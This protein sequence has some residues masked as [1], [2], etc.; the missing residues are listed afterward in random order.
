MARRPHARPARGLVWATDKQRVPAAGRDGATY[1][2]RV[3]MFLEPSL[4]RARTAP[5]ITE[6]LSAPIPPTRPMDARELASLER[7]LDVHPLAVGAPPRTQIALAADLEA[8]RTKPPLHASLGEVPP[9]HALEARLVS[10]DRP[11]HEVHCGGHSHQGPVADKGNQDFQ[12]AHLHQAHDRSVWALFGVADGVSG[13]AWARRGAEHLSYAFLEAAVELLASPAAPSTE[14]TFQSNEWFAV[15][16]DAVQRRHAAR[17]EDDFERI[18]R[19]GCADAT[20]EPTYYRD[21]FLG[22]NGRKNARDAFFQSTLLACALGPVGA[23]CLAIGDGYG[24]VTRERDGAPPEIVQLIEPT[25]PATMTLELAEVRAG[26]MRVAR[27]EARRMSFLFTTDGVSN[28]S[29]EGLSEAFAGLGRASAPL[30]AHPL[31]ALSPAS[32]EECELALS[33]LAR[34]PQPRADQDNMSIAFGV[35]TFP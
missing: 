14:S 11:V 12:F 34:M 27:K 29:R 21:T 20:Y 3:A 22:P 32:S 28:S 24:R 23:I 6:P 26:L 31:D 19:A 30:D 16:G 13:G 4:L 33:R 8:D 18:L 5:P 2:S 9:M 17:V 1:G 10:P 25:A 7:L 15:L 35:R